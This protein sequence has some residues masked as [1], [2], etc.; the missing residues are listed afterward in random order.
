MPSDA[1]AA[2]TE[3]ALTLFRQYY[4]ENMSVKTKPYPGIIDLLRTLRN[5]GIKLGIA[6]NKADFAVQQLNQIYFGGLGIIA[7]GERPDMPRKPDP[8]MV[9][10]LC[11]RLHSDNVLYIGDSDTDVQTALNADVDQISVL[12]GYRTRE[13]LAAAGAVRFVEKPSEILLIV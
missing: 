9:A 6:S 2:E 8:A 1:T 3:Q 13:Q 11:Q 7:V 10:Q 4:A 5:S 12:W